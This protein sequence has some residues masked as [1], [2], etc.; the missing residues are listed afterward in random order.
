MIQLK[1][2]LIMCTINRDKEIEEFF[3]SII[4]QNYKNLE[5]IVVDQ[6]KDDRVKKIVEKYKSKIDIKYVLSDKMGLS[7]N[8][9][10]GMKYITGE[11]IGFPDDD[12][13]YTEDQ[14][15][16]INYTMNK[17]GYDAISI[18][19]KNSLENG[20]LIQE[21][22]KSGLLKKED[23]FSKTCSISLFFKKRVV[24]FI[25]GFDEAMGLG[26][27]SEL[28][29]SEDWEYVLRALNSSF[30]VYYCRNIEVLHPY[31]N[32]EKNIESEYIEERFFSHG[33]TI[34]YLS[35][36]YNL[37]LIFKLNTIFRAYLVMFYYRYIKRDRYM[38]KL[39][40]IFIKG[41]IKY[42]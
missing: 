12:C 42:W 40:G 35:N 13:L 32:M 4:I 36:K 25:G 21:K 18:K 16:S 24:G 15:N 37:K 30:E 20:I 5:L 23:V 29:G 26:T 6:N 17:Y 1:I 19:V 11:I 39:K 14:L 9:N 2:S 41:I 10:L 27:E 38:G 33:A 7:V 34:S 3:K 31:K 22:T 8:R 28:R